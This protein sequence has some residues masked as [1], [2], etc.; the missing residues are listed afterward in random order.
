MW[1]AELWEDQRDYCEVTE[2]QKRAIFDMT[3]TQ[4]VHAL[5]R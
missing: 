5:G 1:N 3:M 2:Q 4:A